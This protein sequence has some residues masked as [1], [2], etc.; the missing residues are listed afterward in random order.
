[1]PFRLPLFSSTLPLGVQHNLVSRGMNMYTIN[2]IMFLFIL[3][4][5]TRLIPFGHF[6]IIPYILYTQFFTKNF[7]SNEITIYPNVYLSQYIF[8]VLL[9]QFC[10]KD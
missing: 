8:P 3:V 6:N 5:C 9:V 1:M 7:I 2:G 10:L 4:R